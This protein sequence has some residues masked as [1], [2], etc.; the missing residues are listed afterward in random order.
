MDVADVLVGYASVDR[1]IVRPIVDLLAARGWSVWWDARIGGGDRWDD[2]IKREI[3]AARCVV[4]V[5]TP[6]SIDREWVLDEARCR[7][8]RRRRRRRP[9]FPLRGETVSDPAGLTPWLPSKR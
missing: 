3:G 6:G 8:Q 9:G 7:P 4:V 1:E 5:G 2:T